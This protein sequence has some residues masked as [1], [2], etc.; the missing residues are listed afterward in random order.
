MKTRHGKTLTSKLEMHCYPLKKNYNL[1]EINRNKMST[2]NLLTVARYILPN[3][4]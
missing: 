2:F 1:K 4:G 3:S